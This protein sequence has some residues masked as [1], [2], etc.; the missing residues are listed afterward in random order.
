MTPFPYK[1]YTTTFFKWLNCNENNKKWANMLKVYWIKVF[2]PLTPP[3]PKEYALYTRFNVDN[4]GWSLKKID[5]HVL[6]GL[7]LMSHF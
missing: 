2:F 4:Y 3:P 5:I 1:V 6:Y 7:K